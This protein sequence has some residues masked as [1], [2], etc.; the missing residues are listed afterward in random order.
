VTE[1]WP[2]SASQRGPG[3]PN[4]PGT[5][6]IA[7]STAHRFEKGDFIVRLPSWCL[8]PAELGKVTEDVV[9]GDVPSSEGKKNL[10]CFAK[11]I[12]LAI[13]PDP[14]F[15]HE[16]LIAFPMLRMVVAEKIGVRPGLDPVTANEGIGRIGGAHQHLRAGASRLDFLHRRDRELRAICPQLLRQA[17]GFSVISPPDT[18]SFERA[19]G[20]VSIDEK[21][22]EIPGVDQKH[23]LGPGA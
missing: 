19:N 12:D 14:R 15:Q 7:Q 18:D 2:R 4:R 23:F 10:S 13:D 16:G 6:E 8:T 22:R 11:T 3:F 20:G 9:P 1:C 21:R 17:P 5:G